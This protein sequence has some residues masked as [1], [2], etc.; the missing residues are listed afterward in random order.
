MVIQSG[1]I[2]RDPPDITVNITENVCFHTAQFGDYI[3]GNYSEF[4]DDGTLVFHGEATVWDDL[5]VPL[6]RAKDRGAKVPSFEQFKDNGAESTGVY[7]YNFGDDDELFLSVQM[8]HSWREGSIIYPHIHL[9]PK[10]DGTGKKTK[11]TLEYEWT[12]LLGTHGNTTI[13]NR[14]V[15]L[16]TAYKHLLYDIPSG[17]IDGTDQTISSFLTCR[18][19]RNAADSDNF[20]GDIFFLEF[21]IHYQIDSVG[22]RQILV[23]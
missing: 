12:S 1:N 21:D 23:K 9:T 10:T 17:G 5:R 20:A 15:E 8:P 22:S 3:N 16:E 14:D 18:I 19:A 2:Q 6:E 7:A 11:L 13:V 4:E